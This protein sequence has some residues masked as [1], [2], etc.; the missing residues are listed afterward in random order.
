MKDKIQPCV[1]YKKP[2]LIIKTWVKSKL[3][4]RKDAI[5]MLFTRQLE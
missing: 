1:A 3:I 5:L 4:E 2:T